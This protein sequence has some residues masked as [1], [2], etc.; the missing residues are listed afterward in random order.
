MPRRNLHIVML[1]AVVSLVCYHRAA[2]NRY[3]SVFAE[4]MGYIHSEYVKPIDDRTLFNAAMNGMTG[5]LDPYSAYINPKAYSQFNVEMRQEFG[6]VGIEVSL[7]PQTKRLM[8]VNPLV[9]TPAFKAGALAGDTIVAIDGQSTE[10]W[11]LEDAVGVLRGPVGKP[12]TISVLHKGE[13]EPVDLHITRATI[14]IESIL[15]DTRNS[16][17]TWNFY[18]QEHPEIGYIRIASFGEHTAA[19]LRKVLKFKDHPIEALIIDVRGNPGG[20][21]DSAV[22]ICDMFISEGEIVS[23]RGRR[24]DDIRSYTAKSSTTIVPADLPVVVLVDEG[25]ASASEIFSAC[26][27]DHKRAVIAGQRSWGK[28]TVQ[29]VIELEGRRSALK[30]TT[31]TYWR[32]SGKNIHRLG[33]ERDLTG[34]WGV[35]PT[36]GLDVEMTQEQITAYYKWRRERDIA[37]GPQKETG[38]DEVVEAS[39]DPVLEKAVE[40]LQ[41]H[42]KT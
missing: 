9:G 18:L 11:T 20:L 37:V 27:Q 14:E 40:Y 6:G 26:L 13:T 15:G 2:R 32:P 3:A 28:G 24:P 4:A 12:V 33:K 1:A 8:I 21:L 5:E 39:A 29:K 34:E 41:S 30:I 17:G 35:Q 7:D 25:S 31:A 38:D 19:E 36:P 22:D 23:T 16:D 42:K 10:G